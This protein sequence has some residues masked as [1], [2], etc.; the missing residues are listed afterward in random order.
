MIAGIRGRL[1]GKTADSALIAVG[2]V[3]LRVFVPLAT[4]GQLGQVGAEVA[5]HTYLYVREDTLALYGFAADEDRMLFEQLLGIS[6]IG[7]RAAL[8]IL[9]VMSAGAFREAIASENVTALTRVPGVG[10]KLAARLVLELRG[11]LV[12]GQVGAAAL[13]RPQA[14]VVEALTGLGYTAE[15][16]QAAA[17]ALPADGDMPLEQR[18]MQALRFFTQR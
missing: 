9:S 8:G 1:E 12:P 6:G 5:L 15:E 2:G 13:A 7:P 17:A 11:K 16:A 3:T 14:E 18:I 4:L 10:K